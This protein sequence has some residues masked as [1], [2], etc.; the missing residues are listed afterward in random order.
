MMTLE[1]IL[2][3]LFFV[4]VFW[5]FWGGGFPLFY[6]EVNLSMRPGIFICSCD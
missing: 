4:V 1:I 2:H 6:E 5:E 3:I